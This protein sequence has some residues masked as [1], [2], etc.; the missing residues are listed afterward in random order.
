MAS[1]VSEAFVAIAWV[2][3]FW[4]SPIPHSEVDNRSIQAL[5]L[6]SL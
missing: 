1:K 6:T 2:F 3:Y 5:S 4:S